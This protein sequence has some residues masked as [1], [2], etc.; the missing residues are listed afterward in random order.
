MGEVE[1]VSMMVRSVVNLMGVAISPIITLKEPCKRVGCGGGGGRGEGG[2]EENA[3]F[4]NH[5]DCRREC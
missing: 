4:N 1:L 3:E 2:R 5:S